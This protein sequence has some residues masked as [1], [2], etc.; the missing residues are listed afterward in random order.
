MFSVGR[1]TVVD[2][3]VDD[4]NDN[5]G[6][7]KGEGEHDGALVI[8][9][10]NELSKASPPSMPVIRFVDR[11]G[12][13]VCQKVAK[14]QQHKFSASQPQMELSFWADEARA[15]EMSSF[16]YSPRRG[17][18][19]AAAGLPPGS[20]SPAPAAACLTC[21]ARRRSPTTGPPSTKPRR[22]RS[23]TSP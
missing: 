22:I 14:S 15:L 4:D 9:D 20:R 2:F 7:F 18:A 16:G 3:G 23:N 10:G 1:G 12:K 11:I 6:E 21:R 13:G 8:S 19:A 17:G 5:E